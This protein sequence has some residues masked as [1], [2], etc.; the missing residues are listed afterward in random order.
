MPAVDSNAMDAIR[1]QIKGIEKQIQGGDGA[2][3]ASKGPSK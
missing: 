3:P 2:P 1:K